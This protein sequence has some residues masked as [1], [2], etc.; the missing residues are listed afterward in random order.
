M[1]RTLSKVTLVFDFVLYIVSGFL[2]L[3][4]GLLLT[5]FSGGVGLLL[6]PGALLFA[7]ACLIAPNAITSK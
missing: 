7:L 1:N 6:V 3:V 4:S 2:I 5:T